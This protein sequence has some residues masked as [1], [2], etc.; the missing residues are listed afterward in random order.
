[1]KKSLLLITSCFLLTNV[2]SAQSKQKA[3]KK[4]LKELNSIVRKS[5]SQHWGYDGVMT[6]DSAFA[7]SKT[8]IISVTVRYTTDEFFMRARMEA[9]VSTISEVAYDLYLILK[10]KILRLLGEYIF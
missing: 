9:P 8:G 4:F 5:P 7:I 2:A 1:M 10:Y 3:E 6:I